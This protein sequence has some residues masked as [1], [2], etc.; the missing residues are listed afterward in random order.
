M[1]NVQCF[2]VF[3]NFVIFVCILLSITLFYDVIQKNISGESIQA[4]LSQQNELL[5]P[6]SLTLCPATGFKKLGNY[7]IIIGL[8]R[9]CFG[10]F[11]KKVHITSTT[12]KHFK[13][14]DYH[15]S[16]KLLRIIEKFHYFRLCRFVQYIVL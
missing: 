15:V 2:S 12:K 8:A 14:V 13:S 3:K 9:L 4:L 11:L 1:L 10:D 16:N 7:K 5:M 6:P